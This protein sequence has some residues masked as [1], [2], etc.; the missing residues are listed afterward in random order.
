V[1]LVEDRR[2]DV[3]QVR[4]T[5]SKLG[6]DDLVLEVVEDG[7][8]ALDYLFRRGAYTQATRPDLVILDWKL[9]L[10]DGDEV[11]RQ[12]RADSL[13]KNLP[14]V[15]FTTSPHEE[16]VRQAHVSGCNAYLRKPIDP[17]EFDDTLKAFGLFWL[18]QA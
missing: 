8:S 4:R 13:L 17:E 6:Y 7:A 2:Q 11:L 10:V 3:R 18:E 1:L 5:F 14:V 12:M 9:P 16:D 15:V